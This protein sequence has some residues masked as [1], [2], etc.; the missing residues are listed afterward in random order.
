LA[1]NEVTADVSSGATISTNAIVS[2][3][4]EASSGGSISYS[5][6]PKSIRKESILGQYQQ[7]IN[8]FEKS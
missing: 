4:A 8:N 5:K 1:S 2:L 3:D 6:E 7:D